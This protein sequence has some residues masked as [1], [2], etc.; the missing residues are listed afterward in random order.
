MLRPYNRVLKSAEQ[1]PTSEFF[2]DEIKFFF[3]A[4][5]WFADF[6]ILKLI[7]RMPTSIF[8]AVVIQLFEVGI[9]ST[10]F[11]MFEAG[12]GIVD[13]RSFFSAGVSLSKST[14]EMPSSVQEKSAKAMPTSVKISYNEEVCIWFAEFIRDIVNS[15]LTVVEIL[16]NL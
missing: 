8:C 12:R 9:R 6:W 14:T 3:E 4:S 15:V 10:D 7:E 2:S 5:I 11:W 16:K 13:F 1:L